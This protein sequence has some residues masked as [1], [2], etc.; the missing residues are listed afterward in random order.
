[1]S[2]EVDPE[3]IKKTQ[4]TLGKYVKKPQL[5][6]KL[7]K[8]PPFR[9]LHDVINAVIKETGF[10][11]GLYTTEELNSENVKEREAK[12][13]FLNKLIDAVKII[14]KADLKVRASKIIAGLEATETNLL[15]QSIGAA[16]SNNLSSAEYVKGLKNESSRTKKEIKKDPKKS[17]KKDEKVSKKTQEKNET[18]NLRRQSKTSLV[19]DKKQTPKESDRDS[20]KKIVKKKTE[21]PRNKIIES[22]TVKV[23]ESPKESI[24]NDVGLEDKLVES[25]HVSE[26]QEEKNEVLDEIQTEHKEEIKKEE[27]M[28]I[29]NISEQ[30]KDLFMNR[31]PS[32]VRPKSARPKAIDLKKEEISND[33]NKKEE[34]T[35]NIKNNLVLQP[36]PVRPRSSLR[37][38]SVRPSSA[39]P[40]APRLRPESA[41]PAEQIVPMGKI[42]VIIENF[43]KDGDDDDTVVV[44]NATEDTPSFEPVVPEKNRG[45]LVEQILSQI[46][47]QNIDTPEEI[48]D[49]G[50]S[51]ENVQGRDTT[52]KEMT[53]LKELIQNFTKTANPLGKLLNYLHE[54][55]E[56]MHNELK[57]WSKLKEQLFDEISKQKKLALDFDKPLVLQL[58][59]LNKEIK[60][61]EEEIS[62]VRTN[63]LRNESRIQELVTK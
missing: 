28:K 55:M 62:Y 1:M 18:N 57:Q 34:T 60:K 45:H 7:L 9:F 16:I 50:W 12:L 53:V 44:H 40:G 51:N 13:S 58:E 14:T 22:E 37:P 4:D 59:N 49:S 5:T 42:N 33:I 3:I 19:N 15:L 61:V 30:A 29:D 41:L 35:I 63:L 31:P 27:V 8:K 46:N 56:N 10:L 21:S 24:P 52:N 36:N 43:D 54:D 26:I 39:R 23:A 38:P 2:N 48:K 20:S 47:D 17:N 25:P 32:V 11:K 6:E